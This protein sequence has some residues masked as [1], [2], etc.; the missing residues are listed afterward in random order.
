MITT[1]TINP[2]PNRQWVRVP[3]RNQKWTPTLTTI[4]P[5]KTTGLA[6]A[7]KS[8]M[9]KAVRQ[10]IL[11]TD[12]SILRP[13]KIDEEIMSVVHRAHFQQQ[14]PV[15]IRIKNIRNKANGTIIAITLQNTAAEM[16]LLAQAVIIKAARSEDGESW[17]RKEMNRRRNWRYTPSHKWGTWAKAPKDHWKWGWR[18][19]QK[20][21]EWWFPLKWH[22]Y[23]TLTQSN[24]GC[25]EMKPECQ[26]WSSW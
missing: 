26:W 7:P 13:N 6:P 8:S 5:P 2:T 4:T 14:A 11:R 19:E 9:C 23:K 15:H 12:K 20:T 17:M 25:R 24:W 1:T 16:A 3:P 18:L 10:L 22:G 21:Q